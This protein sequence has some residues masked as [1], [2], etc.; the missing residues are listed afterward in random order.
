MD[1]DIIIDCFFVELLVVNG[2]VV[3]M[4]L[5]F[6]KMDFYKIIFFMDDGLVEVSGIILFLQFIWQIQIYMYCLKFIIWVIGFDI[7]LQ[8]LKDVVR[9]GDIFVQFLYC[10]FN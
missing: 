9:C 3:L 7:V 4:D 2:V 1:F 6:F 10:K 8:R 5:V